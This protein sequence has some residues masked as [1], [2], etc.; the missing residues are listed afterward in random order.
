MAGLCNIFFLP[1][2]HSRCLSLRYFLNEAPTGMV[3][4]GMFDTVYSIVCYDY[5]SGQC[6]IG[7]VR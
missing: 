6:V 4:M 1:S 7:F 2:F 3:K 5:L